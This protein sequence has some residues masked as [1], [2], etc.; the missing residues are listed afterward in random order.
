ML[1]QKVPVY[2]SPC[3]GYTAHEL[4]RMVY[5]EDPK[6]KLCTWKPTGVQTF[7]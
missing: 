4:V 1:G 3:S 6:L 5:D 7:A 2:G